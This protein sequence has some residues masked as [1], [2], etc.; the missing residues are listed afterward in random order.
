MSRSLARIALLSVAVALAA[1][2]TASA[3]LRPLGATGPL[4]D[5]RLSDETTITRWAHPATR[6]TVR[7]APRPS[8]R[9]VEHVR[10]WTEH[11]HPE[12]YLVLESRVV[13]DR[14]WLRVRLPG[15]PNGRTG[16][17]PATAL[18]PL[19]VVRTQLV[20]DRRTARATLYRD[21]RPTW[22]APVGVGAAG[23]PTPSGRFW[24]RERMRGDGAAYGP[25][26]FGTSASSSMRDWWFGGVIGIHGTDQPGLIPGRPSHGCIRVR[27]ADLVRLVKRMPIGTPIRIR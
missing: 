14:P 20:V 24:V 1:P 11:E 4:G 21:G 23:T 8:A 13:D 17:V 15:R 10:F 25:W 5:E 9:A 19:N 6:A 7:S 26:A 18:G 16:W 2:A 3:A 27:N 12:V 22:R